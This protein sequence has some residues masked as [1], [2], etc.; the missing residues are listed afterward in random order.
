MQETLVRFQGGEDPLEK[1]TATYSSNL[2]W[3]IPWMEEPGGLQSMG[4]QSWTRLNDFPFAFWVRKLLYL[5]ML[6]LFPESH[7]KSY[8][9][10][11]HGHVSY[12]KRLLLGLAYLYQGSFICP[13]LSGQ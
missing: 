13:A 3:K 5:L 9:S 8:C 10:T 12:S 1:E 4:S 7:S 11:T 6:A 2:A